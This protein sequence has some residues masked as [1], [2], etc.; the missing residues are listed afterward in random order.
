MPVYNLG[1]VRGKDGFTPIISVAEETDDEYVLDIQNETETIQTPNLLGVSV[2]VEVAKNT[3]SEYILRFTGKSGSVETPNLRPQQTI[4]GGIVPI[5]TEDADEQE[6]A[7]SPYYIRLDENGA[8]L[9]SAIMLGGALSFVPIKQLSTEPYS[10]PS[11]TTLT[12]HYFEGVTTISWNVP[13]KYV[14]H[15]EIEGS[16]GVSIIN[17]DE[18]EFATDIQEGATITFAVV[19]IAGNTITQNV[20]VVGVP[21]APVINSFSAR[22]LA[23]ESLTTIAWDVASEYIDHFEITYGN[24]T[25]NVAANQTQYQ[26]S[27]ANST[28]ITFKA[29]D[30]FGQ[31]ATATANVIHLPVLPVINNFTAKNPNTGT[32]T[33]RWSLSSA[34]Y[35]DHIEIDW[36]DQHVSVSA[37]TTSYSAAIAVGTVVTLK[38]VDTYGQY[39][40]STATVQA[41][42]PIVNASAQDLSVKFGIP[43][44][45]TANI[46]EICYAL[47]DYLQIGDLI[48]FHAGDFLDL[49]FLTVASAT[50]TDT[51]GANV[52][53]T[54]ATITS[55][56][57]F[58][59]YGKQLRL[60]LVETD[61]YISKNGN[62]AHHLAF[63][64][65]N[66]PLGEV[67]NR[68]NNTNTTTGG[69]RD[70]AARKWVK[71]EWRTALINAGIP[72]ELLFAPKRKVSTRTSSAEILQDDVF[73]PT[74]WEMFGSKT[75]AIDA[76]NDG[77]QVHFSY[78]NSNERR[79]K[80]Y[81]TN[82]STN[83]YFGASVRNSASFC[84]VTSSGIASGSYAN[85]LYGFAPCFCIA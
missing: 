22:K 43:I 1:R 19:D 12:A 30:T 79:V 65:D 83:W 81:N 77:T 15:F 78:Y 23:A 75:Y 64:F 14:H 28:L 17:G 82:G 5:V 73:L 37:A 68:M 13:S 54:G 60:V 18:T 21:P 58:S 40:T 72:E 35:A 26:A 36:L 48:N 53:F 46:N 39:V 4:S 62:T 56:A 85:S 59:S 57:T 16:G 38:V 34:T 6:V 84:G 71:S 69:Y 51:T 32:A 11:I 61:P 29:I 63:Q 3:Q 31:E 33:L 49:L 66:L 27:I 47:H 10:A 76:E 55:N 52:S 45:T 50:K 9:V 25:H 74:E 7:R 41:L 8:E 70:C 80:A 20:T 67:W 2:D 42:Q 44:T 24:S